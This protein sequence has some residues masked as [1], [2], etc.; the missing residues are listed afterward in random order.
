[1]AR[2][3]RGRGRGQG[4]VRTRASQGFDAARR[5]GVG[6]AG[7]RTG[8]LGAGAGEDCCRKVFDVHRANRVQVSTKTANHK[9]K[10]QVDSGVKAGS[11][12]VDS[13]RFRSIRTHFTLARCAPV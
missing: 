10:G 12:Q 1:M 7:V 9:P 8:V 2:W 3:M 13:S 11:I 5:A 4:P 6:G